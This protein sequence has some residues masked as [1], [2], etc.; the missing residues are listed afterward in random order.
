[1]LISLYAD[2]SNFW[3]VTPK[4]CFPPQNVPRLLRYSIAII[5]QP[6][7]LVSGVF[8]LL[9]WMCFLIS[10]VSNC[11]CL[12]WNTA[13]WGWCY[14]LL[15]QN[16]DHSALCTLG[17]YV[18]LQL[19]NVLNNCFSMLIFFCKYRWP[20]VCCEARSLRMGFCVQLQLTLTGLTRLNLLDEARVLKRWKMKRPLLS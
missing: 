7:F 17:A 10:M 18:V 1:M 2:L 16:T 15:K 14:D 20:Y 3:W 4:Q 6:S 9:V 19:M 8:D 5:V 11:G 12:S 13:S